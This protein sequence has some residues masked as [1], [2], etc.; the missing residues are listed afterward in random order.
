MSTAR[1]VA[2]RTKL[3]TPHKVRLQRPPTLGSDTSP[4]KFKL[5]M[6]PN[7]WLTSG[8]SPAPTNRF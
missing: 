1:Y 4:D 5:S 8:P 6:S 7:A 2:S 3:D